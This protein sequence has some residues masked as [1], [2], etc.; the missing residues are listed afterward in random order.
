M[1]Q[2]ILASREKK[3]K[4]KREKKKNVEKGNATREIPPAR[5]PCKNRFT[6]QG[7][8]LLDEPWIATLEK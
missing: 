5:A 1:A 4:E 3:K 7:G 2:S 8:A 6:P